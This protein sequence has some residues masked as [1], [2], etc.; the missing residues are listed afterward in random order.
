MF[1]IYH[2]WGLHHTDSRLFEMSESVGTAPSFY[3]D[4][5]H[6]VQLNGKALP[7][8]HQLTHQRRRL[9]SNFHGGFRTH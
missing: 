5:L 2:N 7:K 9:W 4:G 8:R 1:Y 6:V 3:R